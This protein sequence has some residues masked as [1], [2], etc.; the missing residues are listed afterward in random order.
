VSLQQ[1]RELNP[2]RILS[3]V[4]V[5]IQEDYKYEASKDPLSQH[6]R[7]KEYEGSF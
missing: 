2:F 3:H 5:E 1:K 6:K 4:P 7:T